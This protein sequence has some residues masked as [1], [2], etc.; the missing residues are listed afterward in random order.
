MAAILADDKADPV[1][2]RIYAALGGDE[3]DYL[4]SYPT[5][6]TKLVIFI[7]SYYQY[8]SN[9]R[10]S[11]WKSGPTYISEVAVK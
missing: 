5:T 3:L 8:I 7:S 10:N 9:L 4:M 1:H 11:F 6:T 2:W